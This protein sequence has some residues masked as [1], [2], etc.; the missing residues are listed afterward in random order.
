MSIDFFMQ[1]EPQIDN[2]LQLKLQ[3]RTDFLK[4]DKQLQDYIPIPKRRR[5]NIR[6]SKPILRQA[7]PPHHILPPNLPRST[8]IKPKMHPSK[9]LA[10]IH[11]DP[12][13]SINQIPHIPSNLPRVPST[14][15]VEV[16]G[17]LQLNGNRYP[18]SLL[19]LTALNN[20]LRVLF[21]YGPDERTAC[22]SFFV[23]A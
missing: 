13:F 14:N 18:S 9:R 2:N 21:D 7:K 8:I 4:I 19:I 17:K 20:I 1:Q 6:I 22:A 3:Q 11:P 5:R 15:D 16:L 10:E 12:P 23:F